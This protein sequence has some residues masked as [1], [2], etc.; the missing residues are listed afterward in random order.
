[1]D[2]PVAIKIFDSLDKLVGALAS[3]IADDVQSVLEEKE[4]F[5]MVLAGGKSPRPLYEHLA[6]YYSEKIAWE[7]IR[8]FWSDERYLPPDDP[9]SNYGMAR[10]SLLD[11]VPI[12]K[13]NI[14]PF[15]T[16]Y[17]DPA[18]ASD[19]YEKLLK[20]LFNSEWPHFDLML[21]G[22]GEDCH[23]ASLFPHTVT[24]G[25][26]VRWVVTSLSPE[27]P[28]QRLSL[29]LPVISGSKKICFLATGARKTEAVKRVLSMERIEI[30]DC[31][32]RGVRPT[33]GEIFWWLDKEAAKSVGEL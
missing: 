12:N 5:D 2:K 18:E 7:K 25:E 17:D 11:H 19:A 15:Q 4:H 9:R 22:L 24:L 32:A 1:M 33:A 3:Q 21:L 28:V 29:T 13:A 8:F 6:K 26:Q 10:E 14:F 31:P 16:S 23:I 27:E 20:G 30:E